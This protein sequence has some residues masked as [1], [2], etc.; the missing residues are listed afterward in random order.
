MIS[1]SNRNAQQPIFSYRLLFSAFENNNAFFPGRKKVSGYA[2]RRSYLIAIFMLAKIDNLLQ[3]LF[4][5][6]VINFLQYTEYKRVKMFPI[7][8]IHGI[9][10]TV[11]VEHFS[12]QIIK[13]GLR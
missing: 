13:F 6:I 8:H 7:I 12:N 11:S 10:W 9:N 2:I 4:C 1:F 5:I 3:S